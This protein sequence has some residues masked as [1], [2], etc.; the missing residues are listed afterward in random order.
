[1]SIRSRICGEKQK[2]DGWRVGGGVEFTCSFFPFAH[3]LSLLLPL[4]S[5]H[6]QP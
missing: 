2:F 5:L 6:D 4:F 3:Q 1:M